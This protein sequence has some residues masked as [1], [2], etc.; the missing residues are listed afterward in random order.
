MLKLSYTIYIYLFFLVAIGNDLTVFKQNSNG[1]V[2]INP[3]RQEAKILILF[4]EEKPDF[5]LRSFAGNILSINKMYYAGNRNWHNKACFL[6]LKDGN[7][8]EFIPAE[9]DMPDYSLSSS[10]W[11]TD[12]IWGIDLTG[13][14][15]KTKSV[16]FDIHRNKIV[17]NNFQPPAS[18]FPFKTPDERKKWAANWLS[19]KPVTDIFGETPQTLDSPDFSFLISGNYLLLKKRVNLCLYQ[20][21][22][23]KRIDL[24][25]DLSEFDWIIKFDWECQTLAVADIAFTPHTDFTAMLSEETLVPSVSEPP[26]KEA[27]IAYFAK[28]LS[29]NLSENCLKQITNGKLIEY[30]SSHLKKS[31]D[32][33]ILDEIL[34][35][36]IHDSLRK[37]R[38]QLEIRI[39]EN[40]MH[41]ETFSVK[42]INADSKTKND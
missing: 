30:I 12:N 14:E 7:V 13:T 36:H 1:I 5:E 29:R 41:C 42:L 35:F 6:N 20:T 9:F 17:N 2:A 34:Q 16:S 22:G 8:I 38:L 25:G 19:Q 18:K 4:A 28:L 24:R 11:L 23:V 39:V 32:Y 3:S 40:Q 10:Y 21:H 31:T 15:I 33:Y 37:V 26:S 27:V